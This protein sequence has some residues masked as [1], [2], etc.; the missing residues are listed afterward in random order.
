M[1]AQAKG[2]IRDC[3]YLADG[4]NSHNFRNTLD[5]IAACENLPICLFTHSGRADQP[6]LIS[7]F[8]SPFFETL[9]SRKSFQTFETALLKD[10][11]SVPPPEANARFRMVSYGSVFDDRVVG[12]VA[13]TENDNVFIL[14]GPV[15]LR[16]Q[17]TG[18]EPFTPA[19]VSRVARQATDK[20]APGPKEALIEPGLSLDRLE[21]TMQH[22][23]SLL[24]AD[25]KARVAQIM[26]NLHVLLSATCDCVALTAD[27]LED[28]GKVISFWGRRLDDMP[29]GE[30][31]RF[32][33]R[34]PEDPDTVHSGFTL[35]R[36]SDTERPLHLEVASDL[37]RTFS[38]EDMFADPATSSKWSFFCDTYRSNKNAFFLERIMLIRL[39][40]QDR[41]NGISVEREEGDAKSKELGNE[42][43]QRL[44]E[45]LG[46][47]A[48]VLYRYIPG[49]VASGE[50][51]AEGQILGY[52]QPEGSACA[53]AELAATIHANSLEMEA[54]GSDP[55][56]RSRSIIYRSL[57]SKIPIYQPNAQP[58][59]MVFDD[60]AFIPKTY[61]ASPLISHGC[62]WG[63]IEI[64][65]LQRQQ[66][67]YRSVRWVGE[68]A[69]VMMPILHDHWLMFRLREISRIATDGSLTTARKY[70][71]VLDHVRKLFLASSARLYLQNNRQTLVY[72]EKCNVG[73]GW[74]DIVAST[75]RLD[76]HSICSETINSHNLW[77]SGTI[78]S[79]DHKPA[80]W[81]PGLKALGHKGFAVI[82]IY[83]GRGKSEVNKRGNCF[84][85]IM[86]TSTDN[87]FHRGLWNNTV[88][89]LSQHMNVVLDA[90]HLQDI[91]VEERAEYFAHTIKTRADRVDE[92]GKRLIGLLRPL[93]GDRALVENVYRFTQEVETL[94]SFSRT[95][96][97]SAEGRGVLNALRQT[98][99]QLGPD[100]YRL[101]A[102]VEAVND[103]DSHLAEIRKSV[104]R[105]AGG[106]NAEDPEQADPNSWD[107][108]W[109]DIRAVL[110]KSLKPRSSH[111]LRHGMV[112]PPQS[113]LPYGLQTRIPQSYLIEVFNNLIDNAIKYDFAPPSSTLR[114]R[115][116]PVLQTVE[117]EFRN[118][119]PVLPPDEATRVR[120][121]GHRSDYARSKNKD[122]SGIGLRYVLKLANTWRFSLAY[123]IPAPG[124]DSE[125]LTGLGWHSL[126]LR[127]NVAST[128]Q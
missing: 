113:I 10:A 35:R 61:L 51:Q 67:P 16:D 120:N 24:E 18:R 43:M 33:K 70:E 81:E 71:E 9:R 42:L 104:V 60:A 89:T 78:G 95:H 39:W 36:S 115:H 125:R 123:D 66:F 5:A 49:R 57:D 11:L 68:L 87:E 59:D 7:S 119:A 73:Q 4:V 55:A 65:G 64:L 112:V 30:L 76:D 44:R 92:G 41:F 74:N 3:F 14:F 54:V 109:A 15:W 101:S 26:A 100:G 107:G 97:L 50:P 124:P 2:R 80:S 118:L 75:F 6:P 13:P 31:T 86:L 105:I 8:S 29:S 126:K 58:G 23:A 127:F 37:P 128:Q 20:F 48:C 110:L 38:A 114:V 17:A 63:V 116:D 32:F 19:F 117:L 93:I 103:L 53:N 22:R 108:T 21:R 77:A 84:A 94:A 34:L 62:A 12:A 106:I 85:S 98:F 111:P 72:E 122:G 102:L 47:D 46:A 96:A 69:R 121:G 1:G 79:E 99:P 90:I 45:I 40:L 82:A 52:L 28:L 83:D 91:E 27:H 56:R 88:E 25:F